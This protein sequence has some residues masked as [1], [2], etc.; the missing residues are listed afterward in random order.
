MIRAIFECACYGSV[1][2]ATTTRYVKIGN[3]SN[4]RHHQTT[5][6]YFKAY[7]VVNKL[8]SIPKLPFG[9]TE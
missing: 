3:D 9:L 6:A 7:N 4:V 2:S 1:H 5:P 8:P